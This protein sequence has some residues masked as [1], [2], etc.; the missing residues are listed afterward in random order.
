M[1]VDSLIQKRTVHKRLCTKWN[2]CS[3]FVIFILSKLQY[4]TQIGFNTLQRSAAQH[5]Q[6]IL[7]LKLFCNGNKIISFNWILSTRFNSYKKIQKQSQRKWRAKNTQQHFNYWVWTVKLNEMTALQCYNVFII[8]I[9]HQ[10][11]NHI[12]LIS[13]CYLRTRRQSM[14]MEMYSTLK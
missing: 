2:I 7:Y 6:F 12:Q 3:V 14:A 9:N 11:M 10:L 8:A 13:Y 4:T 5:I 1:S